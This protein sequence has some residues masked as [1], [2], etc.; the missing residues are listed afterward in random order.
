[1]L[2]ATVAGR[3]ALETI[4]HY[5]SVGLATDGTVLEHPQWQRGIPHQL[6]VDL[7]SNMVSNARAGEAMHVPVD[8][9][10]PRLPDG[11]LQRSGDGEGCAHAQAQS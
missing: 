6:G 8:E 4:V 11:I 5:V 9:V 2:T 7:A 10:G 1:M 3:K